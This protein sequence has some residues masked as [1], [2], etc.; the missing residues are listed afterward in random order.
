MKFKGEQVAKQSIPSLEAATKL[1]DA[2]KGKEAVVSQIK[3]KSFSESPY[4]PFTTSTLQQDGVRK[5]N[6]S[7]DRVMKA[8]QKLY[9]GTGNG[10]YITY[11]RTD[12]INLS[13]E[14]INDI[15][16]FVSGEKTLGK[17]LLPNAPREYKTK[18][19]NAQEAHEAIRPTKMDRHPIVYVRNPH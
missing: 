7:S 13:A 19:K 6:M 2:L 9:E 15:R 8:A 1:V 17:Q 3:K 16:S 14:A 4:A 18:A 11:M 5:L 12:L 10:G